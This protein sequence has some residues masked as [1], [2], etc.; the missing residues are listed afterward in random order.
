MNQNTNSDLSKPI[1]FNMADLAEETKKIDDYNK[2][3]H[4]DRILSKTPSELPVINIG[5][6]EKNQTDLKYIYELIEK[7]SKKNNGIKKSKKVKPSDIVVAITL[8][9]SI[10]SVCSAFALYIEKK[11]NENL[12]DKEF[13]AAVEYM[14][15][16]YMSEVFFNSGFSV[17]PDA[18][19]N[20]V[21]T[22]DRSNYLRAVDY[23]M[24]LGFTKDEAEL[25][26]GKALNYDSR[27]YPNDMTP[28]EYYGSKLEIEKDVRDEADKQIN[29]MKLY[30]D[31]YEPEVIDKVK[32]IR[33]EGPRNNARS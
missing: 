11:L 28:D 25:T 13:Q 2:N 22:F 12:R 19:G 10:V 1:D 21:Y 9:L 30:L 6:N 8:G 5:E 29:N 32:K 18:K 15:D 23:M 20:H 31:K 24:G 26:I 17:M 7:S 33:E 27:I 14:N 3:H 16:N 4:P